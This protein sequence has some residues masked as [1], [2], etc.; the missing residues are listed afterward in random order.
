MD[1][2]CL[3]ENKCCCWLI[4]IPLIVLTAYVG[5]LTFNK[6]KE[7]KYIGQTAELKNTFTI[8]DTGDVYSKPDLAITTLSVV[9][10]KKT[11]AD[12]MSDNT[13]KMNAIIKSVKDNGVE[14][15]D[16][17]TVSFYISP[18]YEYQSAAACSYYPCP[19]GKRVL[20]GYQ[21][22]QSLQVKIR[23][24]GKVG[25]IIQGATDNGANQVGDLQFTIEN[26][27]GLKSQAREEAINKV[28]AKA[29]VLAGQLGVKIIRIVSYSEGGGYSYLDSVYSA[30]SVAMGGGESA[31]P[32]IQTGENKTEVTVSITYEFR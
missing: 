24:L 7:S 30:K 15:K 31:T 2:Q 19:D 18:V 1:I 4:A 14:D 8:S 32:Q 5:V 6:I 22:T 13:D 11:V 26:E 20:T 25:E 16:I 29:A 17:K 3:K 27:D 10:E 12:A 9:S 21:V 28:K 23:D